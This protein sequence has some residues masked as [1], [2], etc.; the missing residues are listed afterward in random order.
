M[1]TLLNKKRGKL[2]T[3]NNGYM[4]VELGNQMKKISNHSQEHLVDVYQVYLDEKDASDKYRLIFTINPVCSNVLFNAVTEVVKDEG[5]PECIVIPEETT[6]EPDKE[7]YPNI[8]SDQPITRKQAI[9]DTEYSNSKIYGLTYLPGI[10]FFNNHIMRQNGFNCVMKRAGASSIFGPSKTGTTYTMDE[11]YVLSPKTSIG[12]IKDVFNTI[13]DFQ[14]TEDGKK[15]TKKFP[16]HDNTY[17]SPITGEPHLYEESEILDFEST[18]KSRLKEKRGWFGFYNPSTLD[19]P[20]GKYVDDNNN[21]DENVDIYINM[22]LLNR[23]PCDFIEMFPDS[24]RFTFVPQ[25]NKYR[26]NRLEKNWEYCLT[27]PYSG[28]YYLIDDNTGEIIYDEDGKP[29][30][31]PIVGE[32]DSSGIFCNGLKYSV[33]GTYST[34]SD[35]RRVLLQSTNSIHN[36]TG[37]DTINLYYKVNENMEFDTGGTFTNIMNVSVKGI[38]DK[39]GE[40]QQYYFSIDADDVPWWFNEDGELIKGI[41][42]R[43]IKV[44]FGI[45]CNYYFRLFRRLPNFKEISQDEDRSHYIGKY[46]KYEYDFNSEIN[47]LAFANNI[48]GDNIVQIIYLDDIDVNGITDNLERP[49]SDIYLTIVKANDGHDLWYPEEGDADYQN[50]NI[51]IA[52]PFGKVTSGIDLPPED[53][54]MRD[55]NVH[56]IHNID[57]SKICGDGSVYGD[58]YIQRN[59]NDYPRPYENLGNLNKNYNIVEKNSTSVNDRCKDVFE[60]L[61][62]LEDD[63]KITQEFFLGDM[64]EFSPSQYEESILEP[65]Y[66]RFNT[67]QREYVNNNFKDIITDEIYMDDYEGGETGATKNNSDSIN[68]NFKCVEEVYNKGYE[69][70]VDFA[71]T[72]YTNKKVQVRYPG[73]LFPEGYYYQPHYKIHL[74]DISEKLSQSSDTF[75]EITDDGIKTG[76]TGDEVSFTTAG[77]YDLAIKD[78][79]VIQDTL[80]NIFYDAVVT[81][82]VNVSG[83]TAVIQN[84]MRLNNGIADGEKPNHFIVFKKTIGIPKY[85]IHYPDTSGKYIWRPLI[86]H[87]K[88]SSDSELYNKPFAN[89]AHYRH[90]GLNFF[91]KRQDPYGYY[92]LNTKT[93]TSTG[94]TNKLTNFMVSGRFNESIYYNDALDFGLID[95]C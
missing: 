11:N 84:G 47:K 64:V 37:S 25:K 26:G 41:E 32:E 15:I 68:G 1:K 54:F 20:V 14:R 67:A 69:S 52:R 17:L 30:Y 28:T 89:G 74:K 94:E 61:K 76:S 63:I 56:R 16:G 23:N 92:E 3:N 8:I 49:L 34:D 40:M 85:A 90:V 13:R 58:E 95:I 2:S 48:Y 31:N 22:A 44:V 82:V 43:F 5:S 80:N 46:N 55:Y 57:F 33:I 18:V 38:G 9:R 79:I 19:I 36:L 4:S 66:H 83:I 51:T 21:I 88:T 39:D 78:E 73:N 24:S 81:D 59:E 29:I 77:D 6:E 27:Y 12:D 75:M 10:D 91:L 60:N 87:S 42:G 72:P 62:T 7:V 71:T 35:R 53:G 50:E 65:V 93:E 45:E 70:T 86:A